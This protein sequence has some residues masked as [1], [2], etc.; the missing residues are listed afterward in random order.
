MGL[1]GRAEKMANAVLFPAADLASYATGA[2]IVAGGG[3]TA[4]TGSPTRFRN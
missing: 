1:L 4:R 2:A 3:L